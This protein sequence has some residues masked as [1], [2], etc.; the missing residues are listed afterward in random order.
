MGENQAGVAVGQT[1]FRKEN[2]HADTDHHRRHYHRRD[3]NRHQ[4]ALAG[5]IGLVQADRRQCA[6][7]GSDQGGQRRNDETVFGSQTPGFGLQQ[8]LVPAQ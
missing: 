5:E 3:Q 4:Q 8:I 1:D 6:Q 2:I 7:Y